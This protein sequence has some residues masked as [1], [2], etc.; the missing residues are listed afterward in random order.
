[1]YFGFRNHQTLLLFE[2]TG[3]A[4]ERGGQFWGEWVGIAYIFNVYTCISILAVFIYRLI[5]ITRHKNG[6]YYILYYFGYVIIIYNNTLY[7]CNKLY[8]DRPV[9]IYIYATMLISNSGGVPSKTCNLKTLLAF[10]WVI[11]NPPSKNRKECV[12]NKKTGFW[13]C[14]LY[15]RCM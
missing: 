7:F 4:G 12:Y 14:I 1:M 6:V 15:A 13:I 11:R 5:K 8:S 9:Y 2:H 10:L 3:Y